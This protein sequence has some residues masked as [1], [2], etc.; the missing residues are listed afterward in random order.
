M[1]LDLFN[2]TDVVV[3][4]GWAGVYSLYRLVMDDRS[5][6]A[7]ACLMEASWRIGGRTYSVPINHTAAPFV[8]E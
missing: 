4:G 6:A 1:Q 2:C 5:R 8:Q 7:S 3:G